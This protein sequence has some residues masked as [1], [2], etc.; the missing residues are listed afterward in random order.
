MRPLALLVA[1]LCCT[2]ALGEKPER[3]EACGEHCTSFKSA[4][5]AFDAVLARDP[6][7]L[8]IGEYHEV[9]GAPKVQSAIKRFTKQLLPA[10]KGRAASLVVET[11][12]VDGRCGATEKQAVAEVKKVT[13]RP[14]STED[15]VTTLLGAAYDLGVAPHILKLSCAEYQSLLD[16]KQEL[17]PEKTLSLVG[18]KMREKAEEQRDALED[19]DAGPKKSVVLYGG[20]LHND[21]YPDDDMKDYA[22]GPQLSSLTGKRYVELDLCVPEYV[23]DDPDLKKQPWFADAL[24][25]TAKGRTVLVQPKPDSYVLLFAKTK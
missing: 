15:E 11:W 9:E 22:F 24:K 10:L 2:A 19:A 8:G 4:R 23:A 12:I 1:L 13:K 20:A 21:L 5:A 25:L 18:R 3:G 6:L 16:E 17:D 14:E 7:I